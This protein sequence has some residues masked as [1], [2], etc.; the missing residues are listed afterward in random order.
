[1]TENYNMFFLINN[2]EI[3]LKLYIFTKLRKQI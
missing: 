2:N 3:N 1:M